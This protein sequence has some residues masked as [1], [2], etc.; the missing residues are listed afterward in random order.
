AH[1]RVSSALGRPLATLDS[2]PNYRETSNRFKSGTSVA[3]VLC[4]SVCPIACLC[5]N[6]TEAKAN[7]RPE[8]GNH[9]RGPAML[10]IHSILLPT[11]FS[12]RSACAFQLACLLARE[13]GA[14][15]VVLHVV[16]PPP[17]ITHGEMG[18]AL[19]QAQGYRRELTERLHNLQSDDP[20]V[21]I[22][23]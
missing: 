4:I 3:R 5:R 11:D 20:S 16:E 21:A 18:K 10:P 1:R 19:E 17:F 12:G 23:Y 22:E 14:K 13:S 9:W 15:L 7:G 8:P 6:S 2:L